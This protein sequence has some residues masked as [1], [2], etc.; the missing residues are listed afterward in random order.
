MVYIPPDNWIS[1][2]N[3]VI[4]CFEN[5]INKKGLGWAKYSDGTIRAPVKGVRWLKFT[6]SNFEKEPVYS[7][8]SFETMCM[9]KKWI[10]L[11]DKN[12]ELFDTNY[13]EYGEI[14]SFIINNII[15]IFSKSPTANIKHQLEPDFELSDLVRLFKEQYN[16]YY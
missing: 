15:R 3:E 9:L 4:K 16:Y 6:I 10:D 7:R 12:Q 5:A 11:L 2:Q 13:H 1:Y 14:I 8:P